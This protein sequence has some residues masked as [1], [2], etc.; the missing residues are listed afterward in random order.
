VVLCGQGGINPCPFRALR[1]MTLILQTFG[2][3]YVIQASD[4][5]LTRLGRGKVDLGSNKAAVVVCPPLWQMAVGFSGVA[6]IGSLNIQDYVE[7]RIETALAESVDPRDI[8]RHVKDALVAVFDQHARALKP[9]QPWQRNFVMGFAGL[10]NFDGH[11]Q[12]FSAT[13]ANHRPTPDNPVGVTD[14]AFFAEGRFLQQEGMRS[15]GA[16]DLVTQE[17]R[18]AI[19]QMQARGADPD[20]IG[21]Y[22]VSLLRRVARRDR[23]NT[24]GTDCNACRSHS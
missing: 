14:G 7:S 16:W 15:V 10:G 22:M 18:D 5:R 21:E 13:V 17:D 3:G 4:R 1:D 19:F 9:L 2:R 23:R 20:I 6:T 12:M 24:I 11:G 8:V